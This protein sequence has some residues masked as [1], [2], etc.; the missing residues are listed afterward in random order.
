MQEQKA[1]EAPREQAANDDATP[2]EG[3]RV[4]DRRRVRFDAAGEDITIDD[5]REL[6]L[7]PAYVEELEARARAAEQ[8]VL[9]V[10]A[11]FDQVRGEL[12]RETD[13]IRQR[14]QRTAEERA[15]REK[16]AFVA[17]LLPTLDNL[18]RAVEAA[19][20]G[21][22]LDALTGGLRGTINGFENALATSGAEPV[23]GVV[24][25][26]FDPEV[27]EAVDTV[28]VAPER[29]NTVTAEY[30]R[31]YRLGGQLLRPAR[32]QVGR[33]RGASQTA[34]K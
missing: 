31:G 19:E 1:A 32:V 17:A 12:R 15:T 28:E 3:V 21:G 5:S 33:S 18:Q 10:Q 25:A 11:R 29:D 2:A 24:G 34:A 4:T 26:P 7:K 8:Q 27:H 6:S 20:Q 30:G 14:L 22:T 16:A 13:E 9:D 23:A